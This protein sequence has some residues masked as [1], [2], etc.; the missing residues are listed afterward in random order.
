MRG[1]EIKTPMVAGNG[2][3]NWANPEYLS[4]SFLCCFQKSLRQ[5][6]DGAAARNLRLPGFGGRIVRTFAG[7]GGI[8]CFLPPSSLIVSSFFTLAQ[9]DAVIDRV[10]ALWLSLT[11][12][13]PLVWPCNFLLR[14]VGVKNSS[15]GRQWGTWDWANSEYL[16]NFTSC[17][18]QRSLWQWPDRAV[19]RRLWL[20]GFAG[21]FVRIFAGCGDIFCFLSL[22]AW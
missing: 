20:P 19:G 14:G 8:I 13:F 2:A 12:F 11:D 7:Y 21:I 6:P 10:S 18:F 17:C 15:G 3:R 16:F 9:R 5:W 22:P 1:I 4:I